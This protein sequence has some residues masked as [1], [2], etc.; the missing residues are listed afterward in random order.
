MDMWAKYLIGYKYTI[1]SNE[2]QDKIKYFLKRRAK[3]DLLWR[4]DNIFVEQYNSLL[5]SCRN[6]LFSANTRAAAF[7]AAS[8]Y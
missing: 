2:I 6:H 5:L 4:F 3:Q 8:C 7:A 1:G